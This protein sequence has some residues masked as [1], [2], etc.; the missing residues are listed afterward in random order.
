MLDTGY[1]TKDTTQPEI[2]NLK[3]I[4]LLSGQFFQR[5]IS[6]FLHLHGETVT[7]IQKSLKTLKI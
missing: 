5:Q 4:L 3:M 7:S 6:H 1:A 2:I